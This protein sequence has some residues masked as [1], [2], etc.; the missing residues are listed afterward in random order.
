MTDDGRRQQNF[1]TY[2]RMLSAQNAGELDA[3]M[4]CFTDDVVFEAPYYRHDGPLAA[5]RQAMETLFARMSETFRT[6]HYEIDGFIPAVDPDLVIAKVRGDNVV[7]HNGNHYRNDYLFLV[8]CRE[9]KIAHI[10]EY[11]NPLV[12]QEA[13]GTPS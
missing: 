2:Q 8:R 13:V 12:Y 6:I 9:A 5:G 10:F 7:A 3:F 4:S 1:G 11:S